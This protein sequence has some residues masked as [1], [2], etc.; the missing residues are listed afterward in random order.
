MYKIKKQVHFAWHCVKEERVV[1]SRE[2][3]C[4]VLVL[5]RSAGVPV[6]L[7]VFAFEPA[8]ADG[9]ETALL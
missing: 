7:T 2:G 4:G 3:V 5:L 9:T 8:A 1:Y 6:V